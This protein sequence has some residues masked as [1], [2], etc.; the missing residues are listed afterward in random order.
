[1]V[2]ESFHLTVFV[3]CRRAGGA[4]APVHA[5]AGQQDWQQGVGAA[6]QAA[7]ADRGPH[8]QAK[9]GVQLHQPHG[10]RRL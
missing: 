3:P 4:P 8:Q 2:R 7:Q 6:H 9:G 5:G 10:C 1:M